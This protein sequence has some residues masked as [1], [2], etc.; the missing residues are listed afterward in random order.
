M[1][2]HF[3][4]HNTRVRQLGERWSKP[5]AGVETRGSKLVFYRGRNLRGRNFSP[6]LHRQHHT[7][8]MP[9]RGSGESGAAEPRRSS[10]RGGSASGSLCR[11]INL[12]SKGRKEPKKQ[13]RP[14]K[15]LRPSFICIYIYVINIIDSKRGSKGNGKMERGNENK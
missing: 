13:T 8:G 2:L 3:L 1:Q 11:P 7:A 15:I 5:G 9:L 4:M 14:L 6:E 10:C 12:Y